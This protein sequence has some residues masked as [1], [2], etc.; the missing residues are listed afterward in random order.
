MSASHE[1]FSTVGVASAAP[2]NTDGPEAIPSCE[3]CHRKVPVG[4]SICGFCEVQH[5]REAEEAHQ[6]FLD[7]EGD[8]YL[9]Q[10]YLDGQTVE[11]ARREAQ[12]P[13][14]IRM[15]L[16]VGG[17]EYLLKDKWA[18][19]GLLDAILK[20]DPG[21]LFSLHLYASERATTTPA[22]RTRKKPGPKRDHASGKFKYEQIADLHKKGRTSGQIA[23]QV[24]G[25]AK[26][27]NRVL[28]HLSQRGLARKNHARFELNAEQQNL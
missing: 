24:Y 15:C 6:R 25:D 2:A 26:L 27:A 4:A 22:T 12:D 16:E 18:T 23:L 9:S 1:N 28:A 8:E 20:R 5:L 21:V 17:L 7:Y 10:P 14:F 19:K 11:E 13:R 3:S